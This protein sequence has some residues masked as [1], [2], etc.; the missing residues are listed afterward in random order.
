MGHRRPAR[1]TNVIR[2]V[3]VLGFVLILLAAGHLLMVAM[4][5]LDGVVSRDLYESEGVHAR[6]L[7]DRPV[8][9][10]LEILEQEVPTDAERRVVA[11]AIRSTREG[12][13]FTIHMLPVSPVLVGSAFGLTLVGFA[14]IVASRHVAN[15]ATQSVIGIFA[16]ML[17]WTG[18]VEYGL[19]IAS[20]ILGVAKSF[21]LHG[22]RIVGAL[23]EYVLLKH[24]WGLILLVMIYLLFL[25]SNRCP[26]F[27]WFRKHLHLMRGAVAGGRID[28]FAPRTAFQ[29]ITLLWAFYV[30][31]LWAYDE[32]V[33]GVDGWFTR[34]V[35]FGSFASTGYLLLR[36]FRQGSMGAAI[37]YSI[38]TSIICWNCVEIAAKW[39]LF[40]E[41]WLILNP[42]TA[43][44]LFGAATLGTWLVLRELRSHR[45]EQE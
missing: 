41:P 4:N 34:A 19:M 25:E 18:S 39:G 3:L 40:R 1:T 6:W 31:L 15:G 23:G 45:R 20:R 27:T 14:L 24:T 30:L 8:L 33:F 17:M 29:C 12:Q 28:N 37:R 35:F 13:T 11:E 9:A 21:E 32:T 43:V 44:V 5:A 42:V 38:A 10:E 36:L 16:G 7:G 22:E 26:F 2:G